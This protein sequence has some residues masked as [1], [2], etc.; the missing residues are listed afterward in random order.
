MEILGVVRYAYQM[1]RSRYLLLVILY[2]YLYALI[3]PGAQTNNSLYRLCGPEPP[4]VAGRVRQP[5]IKPRNSGTGSVP[6][7]ALGG[8]SHIAG[9]FVIRSADQ[10]CNSIDI[11]CPKI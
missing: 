5:E 6:S 4:D 3:E 9:A 10:G 8:V 2:I 11:F 1:G 7:P